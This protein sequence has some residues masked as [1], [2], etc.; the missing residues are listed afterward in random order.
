VIHAFF[1]FLAL[2]LAQFIVSCIL[3][4]IS[5][6]SEETDSNKYSTSIQLKYGHSFTHF[7]IHSTFGVLVVQIAIFIF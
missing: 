2:F 4:G 7:L 5:E 1:K 3:K 6:I